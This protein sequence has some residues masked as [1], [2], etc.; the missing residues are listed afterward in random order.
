LQDADDDAIYRSCARVYIPLRIGKLD[1]GRSAVKRVRD[2]LFRG[3]RWL[4][5]RLG[6][7]VEPIADIHTAHL[8]GHDQ[9]R[10]FR[11]EDEA[12]E[13][14]KIVR[15]YTMLPYIRLLTLYQH[16]VHCERNG[17]E[18]SFVECGVWKG[19]SVGLMALANLKHGRQRR[20]LHLFDV[21][22]DIPEPDR[23]LDGDRVVKYVS[24]VIGR[25]IAG[26]GQLAP[27]KG[28]Y[29]RFGGHG[30]IEENRHL[31]EG[32]VR[33]DPSYL[34]WHKGFFQQTIPAVSQEIGDI[35]VLRL[36]GDWYASTKV[37]LEFLFERV[38]PGGI[39]I[40]DDYGEYEGCKKAADEFFENNA[41]KPYLHQVDSSCVYLVQE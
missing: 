2:L 24:K 15:A 31:L 5:T 38:V 40:I 4:H 13:C 16:I 8:T 27:M 18:G 33:Y 41:I 30:S 32:L 26:T 19:G 29:D 20:H 22:D 7:T 17:I 25:P 23:V 36:D 28:A 1:I 9:H 12:I 34:H 3:D 11:F 10:G 21:F 37:C 39:V 35:A 6:Y 14:I